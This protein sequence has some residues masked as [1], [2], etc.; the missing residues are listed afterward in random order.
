MDLGAERELKITRSD[1]G[2]VAC[3]QESCLLASAAG[4]SWGRAQDFAPG[5]RI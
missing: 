1:G 3:L 2:G 4:M 5:P